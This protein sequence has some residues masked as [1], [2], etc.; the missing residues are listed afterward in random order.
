VSHLFPRSYD[1]W[2]IGDA[3]REAREGE[4]YTGAAF[5][6]QFYD[7]DDREWNDIEVEID[8]GNLHGVLSVEGRTD[9]AECAAMLARMEERGW[10]Y[11]G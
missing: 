4:A 1:S 7:N 3:E 5:V 6:R 8:D 10:E 2:R 11:D 9:K